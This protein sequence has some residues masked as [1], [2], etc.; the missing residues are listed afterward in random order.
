MIT[1]CSGGIRRKGRVRAKPDDQG[2]VCSPRPPR[3]ETSVSS[4][5]GGLSPPYYFCSP[6]PFPHKKTTGQVSFPPGRD[7]CATPEQ[8]KWEPSPTFPAPHFQ[9]SDCAKDRGRSGLAKRRGLRK[10]PSVKSQSQETGDSAEPEEGGSPSPAPLG[11]PKRATAEEWAG[12][13]Q[14]RLRSRRGGPTQ[15]PPSPRSPITSAQTTP[16]RGDGGTGGSRIK[17]AAWMPCAP[18]NPVTGRCS[19]TC[20]SVVSWHVPGQ[21]G[22]GLGG[23]RVPGSSPGAWSPAPPHTPREGRASFTYEVADAPRVRPLR[24]LGIPWDAGPSR[25][26]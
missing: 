2:T 19:S 5:L 21:T 1:L 24:G 4:R 7:T 6:A 3:K 13:G 9:K 22:I 25:A 17:A 16:D 26:L 14:G 11:A 20:R 10:E 8:W 23:L 12:R 18:L 15:D